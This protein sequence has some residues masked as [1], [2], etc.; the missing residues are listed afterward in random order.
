MQGLL[1]IFDIPFCIF[2]AAGFDD[3]LYI[4]INRGL[5]IF[6]VMMSTQLESVYF[7]AVLFELTFPMKRQGGLWTAMVPYLEHKCG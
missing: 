4:R 2:V 5:D 3:F 7:G 1:D 6:A